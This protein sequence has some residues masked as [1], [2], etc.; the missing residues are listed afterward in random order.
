MLPVALTEAQLKDTFGD[1]VK[2]AALESV[3]EESLNF[4]SVTSTEANQPYMIYVTQDFTEATIEGVTI[5]DGTPVQNLGN[6]SFIGSYDALTE[7]PTD[8]YFV[9]DNHLLQA[10]TGCTMKGTRAYFSIPDAASVSARELS[11]TIDGNDATGITNIVAGKST[12]NAWYNLQGQRVEAPS[13]GIFIK[14]GK[15]VLVR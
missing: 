6:A 15:K 4:I 9:K 1:D 3:S 13:K 7:I 2:V 10:G 8:A 5:V 12:D 11:I 14:D